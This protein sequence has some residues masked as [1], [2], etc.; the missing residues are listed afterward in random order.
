[1]STI[2]KVEIIQ[3]GD[4]QSLIIPPE[5]SLSTTVFNL[6]QE[7]EKLILEPIQQQKPSLLTVLE[8]LEDLDEDFPDID[9]GLLPLDDI[10][11]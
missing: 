1:M 8:T 6:R 5:I 3:D 10:E 11:L 7:G 4:R 2:C 9:E